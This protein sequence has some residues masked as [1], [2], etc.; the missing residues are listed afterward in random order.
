VTVQVGIIGGGMVGFAYAVA[1]R[2]ACA[3]SYVRIYEAREL[4]NG[5]PD[6]LDTRASALNLRSRELLAAW[7]VWDSL[8]AEAGTI[9]HIHVSNQHRFGSTLMHAADVDS[10][11]LGFVV[12][13]HT[14]GRALKKRA[15][16][17]GVEVVAP[18][19][20]AKLELGERTTLLFEDRTQEAVDWAIVADGAGSSIRQQ[21]GIE[22]DRR[23]TGQRALVFNGSFE[24]G[25]AETAYERFTPEGPLAVLPLPASGTGKRFN[26]VWSMHKARAEALESADDRALMAELQR[27]FGWRQGKVLALGKRSSWD[28]ERVRSTEQFRGNALLVGNAAHGLHPVAGQGLNLSLREAGLLQQLLS[29]TSAPLAV[30]PL[31]RRY[32]EQVTQ[33]Q[34]RV[35]GATD[36]LSNLFNERGVL[37]DWPRNAA[38]AGLDLIPGARKVIAQQGTGGDPAV[39]SGT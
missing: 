27:A 37:L 11:A 15:E 7:G 9:A 21:L 4:P 31:I 34:S 35:I 1:I 13:N 2:L 6:P 39:V 25:A 19:V 32:I 22:L 10:D 16:S 5:T 14:I 18:A 30:T 28:L 36:L 26:V 23:P 8:V 20:V 29:R 12:E 17:L 24:G 3:D 38:L 33:W